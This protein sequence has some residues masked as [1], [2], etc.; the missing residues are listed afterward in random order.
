[1]D[2]EARSM[3]R[4]GTCPALAHAELDADCEAILASGLVADAG[5]DEVEDVY[6]HSWPPL[7]YGAA[8]RVPSLAE[9]R[10]PYGCSSAQMH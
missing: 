7:W 10:Q 3:D 5:V 2:E 4:S 6:A 8:G 9:L 1:V